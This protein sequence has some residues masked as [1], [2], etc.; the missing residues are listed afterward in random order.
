MYDLADLAGLVIVA[1]SRGGRLAVTAP[2]VVLSSAD[3]RKEPSRFADFF[4]IGGR[5]L[6]DIVLSH[7]R[8]LSR[9]QLA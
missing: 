9:P 3:P 7:H 4:S 6:T 5:A 8:I 1:V 2:A